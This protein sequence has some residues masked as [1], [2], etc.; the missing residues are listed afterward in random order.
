MAPRF[1]IVGEVSSPETFQRR[2]QAGPMGGQ[3]GRRDDN[4]W[5]LADGERYVS[6]VHA[7]VLYRDGSWWLRDLSTNG[8]FVN[9]ARSPLGRDREHP[10]RNGD[11]L[12]IG[13]FNIV[14]DMDEGPARP[15]FEEDAAAQTLM[16]NHRSAVVAERPPRRETHSARAAAAEK[17]MW[18]GLQALCKGAGFDPNTLSV[19]ARAAALHHAGLVLRESLIG[20]SELTRTRTDFARDFGV[21]SG[22]LKGDATGRLVQLAAVDQLLEMLLSG[23]G[24]G[25]ARAVDEVRAQYSRTRNH[26]LAVSAAMAQAVAALLER[27]DP[28]ELERQLGQNSAT[29]SNESKARLWNRYCETFRSV[30]QTADA[31]LPAAFLRAFVS[32]YESVIAGGDAR[33]PGEDD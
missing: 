23:R 21:N 27:L 32:A 6:S 31:G 20:F 17:D 25:D 14:V 12:R 10:L 4:D 5:V 30:A 18:P 3:I 19:E 29:A 9:G 26:E 2:W 15:Q 11:K 16:A 22:T 1:R 13:E 7:E 28:A 24:T 8:T 33:R